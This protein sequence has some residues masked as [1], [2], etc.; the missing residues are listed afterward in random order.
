M[1]TKMALVNYYYTEL[2]LLSEEGGT[3]YKPLF[4]DYPLDQYAYDK[5]T[6]NVLLGSNLKLSIQSTENETVTDTSYYFPY[7]TWCSVFN[8]SSGCIIG[9]Q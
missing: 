5:Q 1:Q 8:T 9:P 2:S 3:F 6:H 7:G 4:F